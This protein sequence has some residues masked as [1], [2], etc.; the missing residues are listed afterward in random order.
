MDREYMN[1]REVLL[2][3]A[4]GVHQRQNQSINIIAG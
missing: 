2:A 3:W 4:K 1:M